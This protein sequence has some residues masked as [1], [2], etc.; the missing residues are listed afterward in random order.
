MCGRLQAGVHVSHP[1]CVQVEGEVDFSDPSPVFQESFP[2]SVRFFKYDYFILAVGFEHW[3]WLQMSIFFHAVEDH[4]VKNST[5]EAG[6]MY[7]LNLT[8][9]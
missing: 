1:R 8:H 4:A 3:Q 7:V 6:V 5:R 2:T 9:R